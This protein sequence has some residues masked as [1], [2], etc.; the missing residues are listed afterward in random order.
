MEKHAM[1]YDMLIKVTG[2]ISEC[3]EPEE[4]ALLTAESVKTGYKAKGCSVFLVDKEK[5]RSGI[6]RK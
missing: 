2:A 6:C 4:V 3:R 1:N 5:A